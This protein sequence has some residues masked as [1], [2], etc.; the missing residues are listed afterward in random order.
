[1]AQSNIELLKNYIGHLSSKNRVISKNI[2]NIGTGG[3]VRQD[4]K[5]DSILQ[6]E[7]SSKMKTS[8]SKH[9]RMIAPTEIGTSNEIFSDKSKEPNGGINNVD[10]ETEMA[11]LAQN[12]INFKF[13]SR[14]I[15]GHYRGL[16]EVIKGG[17]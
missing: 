6:N 13:T 12:A 16:R 15:S 3:Y 10:I 14:K 9:I 2:A 1:M 11:E 17:K 8:N 5:F 7:M 4:V